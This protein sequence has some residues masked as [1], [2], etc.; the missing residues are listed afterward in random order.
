MDDVYDQPHPE[1]VRAR[2]ARKRARDKL[3]R[4]LSPPRKIADE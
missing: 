3:S 2:V 4:R 1:Q